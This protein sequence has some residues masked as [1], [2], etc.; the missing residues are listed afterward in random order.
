MLLDSDIAFTDT[1][2][3]NFTS[4]GSGSSKCFQGTFDGQGH[5]ISNLRISFTSSSAVGLFGYLEG[6]VAVRNVVLD[7]SCYVSGASSSSMLYVGG[8]IGQCASSLGHSFVDGC[9]NMASISFQ[10][11]GNK[12]AEH[13]RDCWCHL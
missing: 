10:G 11:G 12:W 5:T 13:G 1:L 7:S 8:I 9:V 2:A 6:N 4:V 3:K